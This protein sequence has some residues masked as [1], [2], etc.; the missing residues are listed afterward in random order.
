MIKVTDK[1]NSV[2]GPT[3]SGSKSRAVMVGNM[4]KGRQALEKELI[5][6]IFKQQP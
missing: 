5:V 3:V 6:Y 4:A 2:L 1:R